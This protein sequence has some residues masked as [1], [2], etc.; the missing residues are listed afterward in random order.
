[1]RKKY[2]EEDGTELRVRKKCVHI[3]TKGK[4]EEE[5]LGTVSRVSNII[6]EIFLYILTS[7]THAFLSTNFERV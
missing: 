5:E 6:Y 2:R 1:M 3:L 4:Q 7:R